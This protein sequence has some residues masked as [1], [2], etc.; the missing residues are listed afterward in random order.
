MKGNDQTIPERGVP[1]VGGAVI[2]SLAIYC[3]VPVLRGALFGLFPG[4]VNRSWRMG[5][6]GL[7][8]GALFEAVYCVVW[9]GLLSN[10]LN[11]V[12]EPRNGFNE[13]LACWLPGSAMV[14]THSGSPWPNV[15]QFHL[16][17][18]LWLTVMV[19]GWWFVWR[20]RLPAE[21]LGGILFTANASAFLGCT[22]PWIV[23]PMDHWWHRG[24]A[25]FGDLHGFPWMLVYFAVF[26]ICGA[27]IAQWFRM[28]NRAL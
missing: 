2:S 26:P 21:H 10:M 22:I 1:V 15:M 14:G 5:A 28:Q 27:L 20:P 19:F 3:P 24:A 7:L 23:S 8:F 13:F 17:I 4:I 12:W 11:V 18:M 25:P 9:G 16:N 6:K